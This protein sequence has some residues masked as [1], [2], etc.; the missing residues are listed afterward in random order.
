M[1]I[2]ASLVT[3]FALFAYAT[4]AFAQS[5][6]HSSP[7]DRRRFVAIVQKIER[8]PLSPSVHNDRAWAIAG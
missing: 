2:F 3:L 4:P 5:N 6:E 7:E 1:K 8:T